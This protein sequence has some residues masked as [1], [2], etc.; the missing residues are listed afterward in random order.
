MLRN[1]FLEADPLGSLPRFLDATFF[2]AILTSFCKC[3]LRKYRRRG[4]VEFYPKL[5]YEECLN[6][7]R[8]PTTCAN[9]NVSIVEIKRV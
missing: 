5:F 7:V 2:L 3:A 1:T 8:I 4:V 6:V 9:T